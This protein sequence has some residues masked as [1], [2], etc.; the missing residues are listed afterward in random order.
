[1]TC[2]FSDM[3]ANSMACFLI[4]CRTWHHFECICKICSQLLIHQ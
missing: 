1:M 3:A 2:G 4:F